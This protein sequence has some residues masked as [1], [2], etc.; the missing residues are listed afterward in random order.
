V[1]RPAAA[2]EPP[3][4]PVTYQPGAKACIAEAVYYES[5]GTSDRAAHAVAHVIL[6]RREH[7]EFPET[8]CGVVTEGCQFSYR[9]NGKPEALADA[10]ERE[11]AFRAAEAVLE[12]RAADPTD[13]ALFF[14]AETIRPGWF[15]TL[16]RLV[17]IGGN[18]FYR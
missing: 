2:D 1:Q 11:R 13:G 15:G 10:A 9:C 3:A 18:I 8:A 17:E 6:N 5:L 16:D 7:A 4:T 12:G 14:H